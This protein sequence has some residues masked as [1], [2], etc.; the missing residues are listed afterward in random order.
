MINYN[1]GDIILIKFPFS[2]ST[3][4]KKRPA[5]VILDTGDEDIVVA[6]ITTQIYYSDYDYSILNWS[7]AGL[8]DSSEVRCHKV[9]TLEKD[10]IEFKLGKL[11][12]AD[13][14]KFKI[15]YNSIFQV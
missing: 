14:L 7:H 10:L 9:A 15:Q 2:N 13:L 12:N 3:L 11:S 5:L 1:F 6:R 8:L 4:I